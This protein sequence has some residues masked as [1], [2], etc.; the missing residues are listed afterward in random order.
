M[1]SLKPRRTTRRELVVE[2]YHGVKVADPYR[3]LEDD[4][5]PEVQ[6]WMEEQNGDFE[7]Y[8]S[9][10]EIRQKLKTRITE[11]WEYAT[12]KAPEKS[13]DY[14]YTWRNNGLQNQSV[15]YRSKKYDEEGEIVFDPNTLSKDGT[16]AVSALEYSPKGNYMAYGLSTSGSDWAVIKVMD[17]RTKE[18]LSES[19]HFVKFGG[20]SWLPDES[21][22][23]YTR[24]P[25]PKV[26]DILKADARNPMVYLHTLGQTQDQDKL[27]Y[28]DPD[29]PDWGF[30]IFSG[31][32]N[33][34]A[35]LNVTAGT[36][37]RQNKL[38]FRP[39]EDLEAPWLP[40]AD[41]FENCWDVIGV[42]DDR[43]YIFTQKDAPFGKLMS[44]KLSENGISDWRTIIPDQGEMLEHVGIVNNQLGCLVLRHATHRIMLYDLDGK[45]IKEIELPAPGTVGNYFTA[46]QKDKEI[47][48]LF[49]SDLYPSTVLRYDFE[50]SKMTT[51]FTPK[52]NFNFSEYETIQEF[53]IS[54][55]GTKVPLFITRKKSLAKDGNNPTILY[56]YGGYNISL[57]PA[58]SN[59]NLAWLE[60]G[61]IYAVACLRG[62][63]EYGEDWHRAG[64]LEKKQNVFD[65]FI[66]AGEY[67]IKEKYTSKERLG[68]M[69]WSNGGLLTGA[70]LTQR[71]DLFGAVM[72]GV[73][74]LDMLRF[75]KFTAGRY[76][77]G[78]YGCA[79]DPEHFKFLYEYSPLHNVKM[80]RVY[81]PTLVM[82]ADTDDR[83]VPMHA[84]KFTA[85]LQAADGGENP[86][87]IRIEKSAG[88]G[89]GKPVSKIIDERADLL[90]F[91]FVNLSK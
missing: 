47:F 56:G 64:M 80:N 33:K 19:L 32:D 70:C 61:G 35:F 22:F 55:D 10:H 66:S 20:A 89:Y 54:K 90:A 11:I 78:E 45:F 13:G 2:D 72:V 63:S 59:A 25:D 15:L 27:V 44:V 5:A 87:F 4:T 71:P 43:A 60:M 75:Y 73:P 48:I 30:G 67:L 3:W 42:V 68:I 50:T 9:S 62:G 51:V 86:I 77:T 69:G 21:G 49:T 41:D 74:V 31:E 18:I 34:W 82:T 52:I 12:S 65:D 36:T 29:H 8:I 40:I 76:W 28:Q 26:D 79:E 84:R 85:A 23:F 88:H 14:Y 17:L 81:P 91:F 58:F 6:K 7:S 46:K 24:Y 83:V 53:Y 1:S 57:T 16:V 39:L 38:Y 37:L